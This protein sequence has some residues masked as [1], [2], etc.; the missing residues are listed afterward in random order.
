MI[1]AL[2]RREV[3]GFY[4]TPVAWILLA[5]TQFLLA[6]LFFSQLEKYQELQPQL[7]AAGSALG[8]SDLVVTPT[9]NSAT[10]LW[11]FVIPLF[12]MHSLSDEARSGRF[13][14]WYSSPLSTGQILLG[15]YLGLVATIFPLVLLPILMAFSLTLGTSLD[16]GKFLSSLTGLSLVLLFYAAVSLWASS[17][18]AR[19]IISASMGAGLLFLLWLLS[20]KTDGGA[21]INWLAFTPRAK[22]LFSGLITSQDLIY[23]VSLTAFFLVLAWH[24]LWR[25]SNDQSGYWWKHLLLYALLLG[26]LTEI[27]VL[28]GRYPATLDLSKNSQH[29]LNQASKTLMS[30]LE[31]PVAI[32]AF[33]TPRSVLRNRVEN[34]VARY[35]RIAPDTQLNFID[36]VRYPD[37]ARR[38][39]IDNMGELLVEYQGKSQK[40]KALN[41]TAITQAIAQLAIRGERWIIGLKGHG[42]A[43]LSQTSVT[44]LNSFAS[45]LENMGYRYAEISLTDSP[46]IPRNASLLMVSGPQSDLSSMEWD[47]L[48]QYIEQGGNLLWLAETPLPEKLTK[49]LSISSLPGKLVDPGA[50]DLGLNSPAAAAATSYPQHPVTASLDQPSLFP[51]AWAIS[52]SESSDWQAKPLLQ[53]SS[54]SWNETGALFG[55]IKRDNAN[56]KQGPLVLGLAFSRKTSTGDI[57][58]IVVI[59]D[60]DFLSNQHIGRVANSRLGISLVHWL[61]DNDK[62]VGTDSKAAPD[63]LLE[64]PEKTATLV[65]LLLLFA[66]PVGLAATGLVIRLWRQTR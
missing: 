41:E 15:K 44:G 22:R 48:N 65:S 27:A 31:E 57:Q 13:N 19:P 18:S 17:L 58:K 56:E 34:L 6:W 52:F 43:S 60:A 2:I 10:L 66:I 23:L 16:A 63:I 40:V 14:L 35:Q 20:Q 46:Q 53:S 39:G 47:R 38:L 59:T 54:R 55:R 28:A 7:S 12:A 1:S 61:T 4:A 45:Q 50:T 62:L 37:Q 30:G 51:G 29:S 36:P 24:R 64:W 25:A 21:V 3:R 32:T 11:I 8:V 5:L 26:I 42:E 33:V 9:L 49:R